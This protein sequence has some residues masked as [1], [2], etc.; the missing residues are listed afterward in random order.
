MNYPNRENLNLN[1]NFFTGF[2]TF[3]NTTSMEKLQL[4]GYCACESEKERA[5]PEIEE[6][7]TRYCF[8]H[9]NL[10]AILGSNQETT[11]TCRDKSN[12]QYGCSINK[13][14]ETLGQ[15]WVEGDFKNELHLKNACYQVNYPVKTISRSFLIETSS[16]RTQKR[17]ENGTPKRN[18]KSIP[19]ISNVE[20][21]KWI[22]SSQTAPN[23]SSSEDSPCRNFR[24]DT[25]KSKTDFERKD[26]SII[27]L[28]SGK[29]SKRFDVVKKTIFRKVK[30][31]YATDFKRF[32]DYTKRKRRI[33]YD[34]NAEIFTQAQ[35]YV[36]SKFGDTGMENLSLVLVAMIDV[37]QKYNHSWPAFTEMRD[38]LNRLIKSFNLVLLESILKNPHYAFL[39]LHCLNNQNFCSRILDAKEDP[40]LVERYHAQIQ[41]YR[42]SLAESSKI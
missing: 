35:R 11:S 21:D 24:P 31:Y 1:Q 39:A 3:Q 10:E 19:T 34:Y 17:C 38:K 41:A 20:E 27:S 40:S 36:N 18:L 42:R 23:L 16:L 37:K 13:T 29:F 22:E 28:P 9:Y 2:K 14:F 5:N 4:Q 15:K 33:G 26:E 7:L 30:K 32:Y 8:C 25:N 6:L 12:N